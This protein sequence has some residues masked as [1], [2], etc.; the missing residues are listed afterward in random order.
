[1]NVRHAAISTTRVVTNPTPATRA[2][3]VA[4]EGEPGVPFDEVIRFAK[5]ARTFALAKHS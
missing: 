1:M 3:K 2:W 5:A 4:V